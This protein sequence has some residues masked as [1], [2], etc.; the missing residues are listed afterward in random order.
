[1]SFKYYFPH[2]HVRTGGKPR[3]ASFVFDLGETA[4]A[5][6]FAKGAA[7]DATVIDVVGGRRS[8]YDGDFQFLVYLVHETTQKFLGVLRRR[9]MRVYSGDK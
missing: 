2:A 8:V 3:V 6:V 4:G 9:K 7:V 5:G 1:M